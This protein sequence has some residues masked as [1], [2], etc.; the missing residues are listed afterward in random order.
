MPVLLNVERSAIEY[1]L[2]AE[3]GEIDH[4]GA[5]RVVRQLVDQDERTGLTILGVRIENDRPIGGDSLTHADR[6]SSSCFAAMCSSVLTSILCSRSVML[7]LTVRGAD[8]HEIGPAGKQR[9]FVHPDDVRLKL[10][11]HRWRRAAADNDVSAADIDFVLQRQRHRLRRYSP[12]EIALRCATMRATRLSLPEGNTRMV[13]P[14]FNVPLMTMPAKPRKSWLGRNFTHCT[15]S[16]RGLPGA[17]ILSD[18]Y[19]FQ[20]ADQLSDLDTRTCCR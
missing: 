12:F 15:G 11:G 20:V 14:L 6:W 5:D 4:A 17:G 19:R 13:S 1:W 8:L 3:Q 2:R 10:I 16:R 18:R 9:V 7:A